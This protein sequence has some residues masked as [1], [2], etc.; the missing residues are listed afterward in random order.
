MKVGTT[1]D[2]MKKLTKITT[3]QKRATTTTLS[4]WVA[5]VKVAQ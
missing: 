1:T 4:I 2:L 5:H 3:K